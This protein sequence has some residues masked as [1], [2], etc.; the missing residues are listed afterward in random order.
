MK[1]NAVKISFD[2]S[3]RKYFFSNNNIEVKNDDYVVVESEK[4]QQIGK[5]VGN[6]IE[7]EKDKLVT[8]LQNIIRI[9]TKEDI[10]I[11]NKNTKDSFLALN[12]AKKIAEKM[13]LEMKFISCYYTFDRGQLIFNFVADDRIDFRELAKKLASIYKTRIEL[14]QVGVR[15]KAKEVGGLGPCGRF[16]CCNLFLK[17]FES[18]SINMAKNQYISLKPDKINGVCGRLLCCLNY[19]DDQYTKLKRKY[20]KVGEMIKTKNIEGKVVALN[21]FQKSF[22][23]EK[24]DRT[25]ATIDLDSYES[26]K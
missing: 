12:K 26:D 9:A 15:D 13:N 18:V 7:I 24:K 14:R 21:L 11:Y 5:I 22:T 10:N 6:I 2:N 20:P 16:L 25:V 23:I 19:E 17:D 3:N 4:G 1:V 8:N